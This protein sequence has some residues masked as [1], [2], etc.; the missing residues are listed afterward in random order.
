MEISMTKIKRINAKNISQITNT[1]QAH[2]EPI[3]ITHLFETD[4]SKLK[5]FLTESYEPQFFDSFLT[6]APKN[7]LD[8]VSKLLEPKTL[9]AILDLH[10]V[11]QD[12]DRIWLHPKGNLTSFHFDIYLKTSLHHLLIGTKQWMVIK[13]NNNIQTT[14]TTNRVTNISNG[15][16]LTDIWTGELRENEAIYVPPGFYHAVECLSEYSVSIDRIIQPNF[17][18]KTLDDN[19]TQYCITEFGRHSTYQKL[20][21]QA[22]RIEPFLRRIQRLLV[23]IR[24]MPMFLIT[25]KK[26]K[27]KIEQMQHNIINKLKADN[28]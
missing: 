21:Y 1:I 24:F 6:K 15:I 3:I 20:G 27:Q 18:L 11:I 2:Q 12:F 26:R 14:K 8:S 10:D 13:P 9:S 23:I 7:T 5:C 28:I 4:Q 19:I 22:N 17:Q 16:K 25:L